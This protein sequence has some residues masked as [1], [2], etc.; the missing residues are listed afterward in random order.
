MLEW[1]L[2]PGKACRKLHGVWSGRFLGTLE[3]SLGEGI[4]TSLLVS[5]QGRIL[6]TRVLVGGRLATDS[7]GVGVEASSALL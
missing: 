3:E 2:P 4:L 1:E 7:K 6:D 5:V